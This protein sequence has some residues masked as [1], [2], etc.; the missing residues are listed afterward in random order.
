MA[1]GSISGQRVD[2][3]NVTGV[4]PVENG[5]TGQNNWGVVANAAS[6]FQLIYHKNYSSITVSPA[7]TETVTSVI[8]YSALFIVITDFVLSVT[9]SN[10]NV[11]FNYGGIA[12]HFLNITLEPNTNFGTGMFCTFSSL[13]YSYMG[14][15]AG[16]ATSGNIQF[17]EIYNTYVNNFMPTN[18]FSVLINNLTVP[19]SFKLSVYGLRAF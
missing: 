16:R 2:L 19:V 9:R 14:I 3:S 12:W 5:G 13:A 11:E 7:Y 17:N 15:Y 8:G 10:F 4:L 1:I 18:Q 6:N